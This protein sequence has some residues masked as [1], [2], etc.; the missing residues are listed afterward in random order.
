ML[1]KGFK[2]HARCHTLPMGMVA[3]WFGSIFLIHV[4]QEVYPFSAGKCIF[5]MLPL[6][7]KGQRT[8][9]DQIFRVLVIF[10]IQVSLDNLNF[11]THMQ[12]QPK[13]TVGASNIPG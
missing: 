7:E 5:L 1:V 9:D 4:L 10:N 12:A 13:G 6:L 2:I 3:E 11:G 8:P